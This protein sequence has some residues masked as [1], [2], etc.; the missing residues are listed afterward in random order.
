M[1]FQLLI[2]IWSKTKT[3]FILFDQQLLDQIFEAS[4]LLTKLFLLF[5]TINFDLGI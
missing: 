2:A 1:R 3:F 4:L 5:S